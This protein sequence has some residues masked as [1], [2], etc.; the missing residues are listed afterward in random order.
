MLSK[1]KFIYISLLIALILT[2]TVAVPA[3]ALS[4]SEYFSIS[5]NSQFSKTSVLPGEAFTATV[6]GTAVCI[7]TLPFYLEIVTDIRITGEIVAVGQSGNKIILNPKY[8][9][10]IAPFP[11][12]AGE[13][14]SAS[15]TL[16]LT[17]SESTPVGNYTIMGVVDKVEGKAVLWGDVTQ[18]LPDNQ[19]SQSFGTVNVSSSNSGGGGGFGGGG[20]GGGG[21]TAPVV[22]TDPNTVELSKDDP[23]IN[24]LTS[25]NKITRN[26][27]LNSSGADCQLYID[28]GTTAVF[29]TGAQPNI[30]LDYTPNVQSANGNYWLPDSNFKLLPSGVTFNPPLKM[31][32]YLSTITL[33]SN[34]S[35]K[36]LLIGRLNEQTQVWERIPCTFDADKLTLTASIEHF[37][38]YSV[39]GYTAPASFELSNL[40]VYPDPPMIGAK[41]TARFNV[42]NTGDLQGSYTADLIVDGHNKGQKVVTLEGKSS[43]SVDIDFFM[44]SA[45]SYSLQVG[46]LKQ[47]LIVQ[48]LNPATVSTTPAAT[49]AATSETNPTV[50]P[51]SQAATKTPAPAEYYYSYISLSQSQIESGKSISVITSINNSGEI[52]GNCKV[53]LKVDG[54]IHEN[55]DVYI[56]AGDAQKVTFNLQLDAAGKH[57]ISIGDQN[58]VLTVTPGEKKLS[59]LWLIPVIIAVIAAAGVLGISFIRKRNKAH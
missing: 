48:S 45:G 12:H 43:Q 55:R 15:Q 1:S 14:T 40:S 20:G 44:D 37:S 38:F 39:I 49:P 7:K 22:S 52:A 23:L 46:S 4:V 32:V 19:K 17:F 59:L 51:T 56:S 42:S 3:N 8:I 58:A 28:R 16:N 50:A 13:N 27:Y 6:S 26:V 57:T 10:N 11:T 30:S 9:L 33:P 41:I 36:N 31:T 54:N 5:Y 24:Y 21:A 2:L 18:Y 25:E 29:P 34:L 47:N 35:Y 53:V